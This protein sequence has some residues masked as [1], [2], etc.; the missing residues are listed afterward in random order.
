MY[1]Q[2]K[3]FTVWRTF[4]VVNFMNLGASVPDLVQEV[5]GHGRLCEVE[6]R[7][8]YHL[9]VGILSPSED[10]SEGGRNLHGSSVTTN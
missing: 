6:P 10:S 3:A 1:L 9:E 4:H 7:E 8:L 5:S 2:F